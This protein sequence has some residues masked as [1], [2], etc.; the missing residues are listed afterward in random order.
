MHPGARVLARC[1][2]SP[3]HAVGRHDDM[4]ASFSPVT[5]VGNHDVTRLASQLTEAG[6]AGGSF[7]GE[8]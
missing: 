3:A 7:V 2:E 8:L 6:L 5:F 1:H 4:C